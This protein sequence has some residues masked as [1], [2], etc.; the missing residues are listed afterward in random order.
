MFNKSR[1][2][3]LNLLALVLLSACASMP[4]DF[5]EPSVTLVSFLP[6]TSD[7]ISPE[8]EI[9]LRVTNPNRK[10]LE[11]EGMSYTLSLEGNKV[12]SGVANNLPV[13]ESYGEATVKL[14]ATANIFGSFS[15]LTGLLS[16]T[17]DKLQYEFNAKLDAGTFVPN[18]RVSKK[19]LLSLTPPK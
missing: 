8:F 13:I 17:K 19:G 18:I 16:S 15:L 4:S 14:K 10:A 2:L 7:S 6:V 1:L 5:E 12:L 3:L 9:L 11:L